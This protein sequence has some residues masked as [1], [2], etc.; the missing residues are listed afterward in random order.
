[1]EIE[2]RKGIIPVDDQP[3]YKQCNTVGYLWDI[4]QEYCDYLYQF[5]CAGTFFISALF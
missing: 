1:M 2:I 5:N 4:N 3:R